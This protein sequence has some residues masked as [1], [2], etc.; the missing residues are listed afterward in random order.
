MIALEDII[1]CKSYHDLCDFRYDAPNLDDIPPTG[2]VQVPLDQIENFFQRIEGN[3]HRYIV[4]SSCSD[5]GL[6]YQKEHPVWQD[7]SKWITMQVGPNLGYS[8]LGKQ[9]ARCNLELCNLND[10]YSV[11]CHAFTRATFHHIPENVHHWF[12]TNL[13]I[14]SNLRMT[15]LP[16]GIA[17]GKAELLH[18]LLKSNDESKRTNNTYI[19]WQDYTYERY[20][21][22]K[23]LETHVGFTVRD[24]QKADSYFEYLQQLGR[25]GYVV[26]PPGNGCDCYRTLEA[27]YMGATVLVEN[28]ITNR[29]LGLPTL[30]YTSEKDILEWT[31]E[32][33]SS[34]V[35][36]ENRLLHDKNR[37]TVVGDANKTK[38]SYWKERFLEK[39]QEI[40]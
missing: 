38:L 36:I 34:H 14:K 4:V 25:H 5:Y 28:T 26:S 31:R 10:A 20:Q 22:R 16:F 19:S 24:P 27:I 39:R 17:E 6:A 33:P 13:M 18:G 7:M 1:T 23:E 11:K 40:I 12:V 30:R 32:D 35:P 29:L 2:V 15:A 8:N 37:H 9:P 21:L 3:G